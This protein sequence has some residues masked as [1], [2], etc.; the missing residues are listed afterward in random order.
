MRLKE[1]KVYNSDP[2]GFAG[3]NLSA[4]IKFMQGKK[5]VLANMMVTLTDVGTAS[6]IVPTAN[7]RVSHI[8]SWV[9]VAGSGWVVELVG[10]FYSKFYAIPAVA[11]GVTTKFIGLGIAPILPGLLFVSKEY[12]A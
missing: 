10:E 7:V 2:V 5:E 1:V 12:G 6:F 3:S 8:E 4:T 9:S 11:V